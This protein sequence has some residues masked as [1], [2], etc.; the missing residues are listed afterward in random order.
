[1]RVLLVDDHAAVRLRLKTL[2]ESDFDVVD[3]AADG[4]DMITA[5][6]TLN[7]DIIVADIEMPRLNGIDASREILKAKPGLP[8]VIVSMHRE[9]GLVREALGVGVRGYIDKLEA[10]EELVPAMRSA[11]QGQT[12]VSPSCMSAVG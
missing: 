2:L 4:V 6:V 10:G 7:P 11:L 5:A 12:F 3:T 1:M 9:P 8:I